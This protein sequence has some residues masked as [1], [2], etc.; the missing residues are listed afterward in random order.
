MRR[1]S[2]RQFMLLVQVLQN[3]DQR[4]RRKQAG[5]R[6]RGTASG[7]CL[8]CLTL[9]IFYLFR[10]GRLA[11]NLTNNR[12]VSHQ[13]H[14]KCITNTHYYFTSINCDFPKSLTFVIGLSAKRY[15]ATYIDAAQ[16]NV[17]EAN[18]Q[19]ASAVHGILPVRS[20]ADMASFVNSYTAE[21]MM[22]DK[23]IDHPS[24]VGTLK[25]CQPHEVS[26]IAHDTNGLCVNGKLSKYRSMILH[27]PLRGTTAL[28]SI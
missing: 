1:S 15:F 28:K 22:R 11:A 9:H 13:N 18:K 2:A 17:H 14:H 26:P 23:N 16:Q 19:L 3:A 27:S 20:I 21:W 6:F 25:D 4:S 5:V 10:A 7:C 24:W 12:R 8:T